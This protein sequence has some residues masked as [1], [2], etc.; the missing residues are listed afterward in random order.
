MRFNNH[1]DLIGQHAFLSASKY[2]WVNYTD[3]KIAEAYGKYL[4]TQR[5]TV[6]H[7]FASQAIRLNQKLANTKSALNRYVNDAIGFRMQPEQVLYYSE[8]AFGTADAI[9]FRKDFLRIHDL[10]T[11]VSPVYMKQLH[12]YAALFCLEYEVAP[13]AIGMELRI[14][15]LEETQVEQPDPQIILE[16]MEKI[17]QFDKMI[18][19]LKAEQEA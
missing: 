1:S 9:A 2:H 11:G 15:Q 19:K 17:A 10:K 6:L 13:T 3:S 16:V 8:N 7:D 14:Y 4:A 5:G 12:I 18:E